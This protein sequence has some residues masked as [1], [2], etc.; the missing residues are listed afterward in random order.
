MFVN[1]KET[2]KVYF[3]S[4][5]NCLDNCCSAPMVMLAPL[6]LDDF[7]YVYKKFLIQFAYINNELKAV[8]VIN[9]GIGSCSY[10]K[11][12][13]CEIYEERPPA[14][15]MFPI[16]PYFNEF[17]IYG[18]C[19]AL[20]LSEEHGEFICDSENINDN[21]LHPRVENF[22]KKLEN[23]KKFL[24]EIENDLTP[25]IKILN[26]Q[27]FNYNGSLVDN[28]YLKMYKESLLFE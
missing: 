24:S 7:L 2:G 10:Y 27:L 3:S 21:F 16:S 22:V 15:K 14:C 28:S 13:R 4:C 20:S 8:M 25:S 9:K 12:N 26:I 18:K 17:Y 23:T 1:I 19:S 5:E 11:N 6:V